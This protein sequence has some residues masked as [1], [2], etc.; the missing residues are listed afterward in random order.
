MIIPVDPIP[1]V[2]CKSEKYYCFSYLGC[3]SLVSMLSSLVENS[4]S[5]F[6]QW[7]KDAVEGWCQL[8]IINN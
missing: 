2:L 6:D 1:T 5:L 4:S 3:A 7:W 8:N